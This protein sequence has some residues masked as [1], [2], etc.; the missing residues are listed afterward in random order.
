MRPSGGSKHSS[1]WHIGMH[2]NESPADVTRPREADPKR[3]TE[4]GK[5]RRR[6]WHSAA[7]ALWPPSRPTP[8]V[9]SLVSIAVLGAFAAWNINAPPI[10]AP[11]APEPISV[12]PSTNIVSTLSPDRA[13]GLKPKDTFT[14]CSS[15]PQMIVVPPGSF[16][17]GSP[18]SEP[19]RFPTEGPQHM[20][21][22]ARPFAVQQFALGSFSLDKVLA[23]ARE[24]LPALAHH[25]IPPLTPAVISSFNRSG[26]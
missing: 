7:S 23:L 17:M 26:V 22:F 25:R 5:R 13:R 1:V 21:T 14:E 6:L 8:L 15:C 2:K 9:A 4:A 24:R 11:S 16:T 18:A 19:K 12:A 10:P 3:S 20:V